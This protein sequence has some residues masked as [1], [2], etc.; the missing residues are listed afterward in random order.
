[1]PFTKKRTTRKPSSTLSRF[2]GKKI[3]PITSD[4]SDAYRQRAKLTVKQKPKSRSPEHT[5]AIPL[6]TIAQYDATDLNSIVPTATSINLR[7]DFNYEL[8][9]GM[10]YISNPEY[11]KKT[12]IVDK[13]RTLFRRPKIQPQQPPTYGILSKR[14]GKKH[15]LRKRSRQ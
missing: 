3:A 2:Y 6:T 12:S 9:Q 13:I 14:G 10:E 15:T 7:S 1:M 11:E 8:P 5:N 4:R